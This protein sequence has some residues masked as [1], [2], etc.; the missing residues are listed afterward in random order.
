MTFIRFRLR[1]P[2]A[3]TIL[4]TA[5]AAAVL[6]SCDRRGGGYMVSTANPYAS[7]AAFEI[8]EKGGSAVDAAITA[9]LVLTLVEPQ[10]SGIGGGAFLMHW[11][12]N[13]RKVESYDGRE[14]APGAADPDLF[15]DADRTPMQFMDA[16]VGGR[17]VGV[18]G[19]IAMFWKAHREHGRL[20]WAALFEPAIKLADEG[21]RVSPRLSGMIARTSA[22]LRH[23][24]TRD[25]FFLKPGT[26]GDAPRPLPAG[27]MLRNPVYADTLRAIARHGPDGF[28]KGPVAEAI[29]E[30][31]SAHINRGL[32][33]LD[34]LAGYEA[35]KREP[36]CRG[37]RDRTVCGMPPPTSGGL[38]GLMILGMLEPFSMDRFRPGS[39]MAIHLISEASRLAYADRAIYMADSDFADV[40]IRG[41][42]DK[43]YLGSRTRLINP[44]VTMGRAQAGFPA[45]NGTQ[46]Q[47][48]DH[49]ISRPSTSHLAIV[50]ARGNAV[51]MTMSVEGPFGAHIM[52][53]GFVL[54]NQLTDFSFVPERDGTPVANRVEAGKRPRS[55]MSPTIILDDRGGFFAAVGSPGGSRIIAYVAQTVV[56]LIDWNMD[57]QSAI[58]MPR[59]VNRNG[60]VELEAGTAIAARAAALEALGHEVRTGTLTSGLHGIRRTRA[61]L[62]GGADRRR[63]GVVI[64]SGSP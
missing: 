5:F 22:L 6:G 8:L 48:P 59:H 30:T 64:G 44:G 15:L 35:R 61:G 52:A 39:T 26:G 12:E 63:E 43:A 25:Y 38:T 10:S 37:Y 45:G 13:A 34:D 14:M 7:R 57:M 9:Q 3:I 36:V 56:G 17:S 11:D 31:A 62:D 16:V 19:V 28:Y 18:P 32:I 46:A 23:P 58:D 24:S 54:N 60:P 40:P 20:E 21:F 49:D 2:P 41:L 55:S 51:S 29:V 50:D 53:A 47:A 4:A 1:P 42:L 27:H 33:T